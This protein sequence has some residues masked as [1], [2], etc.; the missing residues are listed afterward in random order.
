[1]V[2]RQFAL[3]RLELTVDR[4]FALVRL[5]GLGVGMMKKQ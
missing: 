4:Q 1:M 2:D 5:E 3:V